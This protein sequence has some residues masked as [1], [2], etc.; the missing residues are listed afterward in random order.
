[1][2]NAVLRVQMQVP[3]PPTTQQMKMH[4]RR[5]LRG[6]PTVTNF[7]YNAATSVSKNYL[8]RRTVRAHM[9][10]CK[11]RCNLVIKVFPEQVSQLALSSHDTLQ[12]RT[13][14]RLPSVSSLPGAK[15]KSHRAEDI[16]GHDSSQDAILADRSAPA[17]TY[18]CSDL[19]WHDVT[20]SCETTDYPKIAATLVHALCTHLLSL[21]EQP[22]L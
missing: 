13:K 5:T 4:V 10:T 20:S 3:H 1:M 7:Q 9:L 22:T 6:Y 16:Q 19:P 2:S 14:Y 12:S 21:N 11:I 17:P 8:R 15:L 18:K